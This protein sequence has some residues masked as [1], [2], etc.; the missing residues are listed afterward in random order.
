MWVQTPRAKPR[1]KGESKSQ[2][3]TWYSTR[4]I[5]NQARTC[6]K[7]DQVKSIKQSHFMSMRRQRQFQSIQLIIKNQNSILKQKWIKQ[8]SKFLWAYNMSNTII[9]PK[10]RIREAQLIWKWKWIRSTSNSVTHIVTPYNH[11]H[12]TEMKNEKNTKPS[13]KGQASC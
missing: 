9:M 5:Y 2:N 7:K 8:F 6:P 4:S 3:R 11:V 12:K 1:V 13:L 10:I